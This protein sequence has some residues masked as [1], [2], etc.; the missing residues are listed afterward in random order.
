M[1]DGRKN[2]KGSILMNEFDLA[3]EICKALEKAEKESRNNIY[4][5]RPETIKRTKIISCLLKDRDCA[6]SF[7]MATNSIEICVLGYV[8]D[9][10]VCDL[11]RVFLTVDL[12]VIDALNDGKVSIEMKI[13]NAAEIIRRD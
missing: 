5:L 1:L 7:D 8:F 10:C 3:R 13:L 4:L 2:L 12:F 9:S 11:K 6:I